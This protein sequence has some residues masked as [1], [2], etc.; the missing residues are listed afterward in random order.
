MK[1]LQMRYDTI[2]PITMQCDTIPFDFMQFDAMKNMIA[3]ISLVQTDSKSS[4]N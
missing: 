4:I 2:H 3:F 1:Q